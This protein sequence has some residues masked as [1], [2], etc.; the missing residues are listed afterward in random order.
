MKTEY[1][2]FTA[3]MIPEAGR[4]LAD[5]HSVNRHPLPLLPSRFEDTQA[6]EPAV[7]AQWKRKLTDGFAAFR[8]GS[9]VAYL[10]GEYSVQP[11]GRCGYGYLPGYALAAGESTTAFQDLYALL[12]EEW[13][14]KGVFSHSFYISA[15]DAHIIGALFDVGFGKERVDALLDLRTVE[16]PDVEEPSG[17]TIRRAGPGDNEHLGNLSDVIFRALQKPHTGTP[18]YRKIG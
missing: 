12:G 4:L 5:R 11:W 13:V 1:R 9:M 18:P 8:D 16:I 7:E 14:K 17:I 10:V 6:A 15:A 2:K 3:D